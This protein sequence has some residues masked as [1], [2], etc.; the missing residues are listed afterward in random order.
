MLYSVIPGSPFRAFDANGAPLAGGKVYTW[1]PGTESD[2]TTWQDILGTTPNDN[3]VVLDATGSA[4]IYGDQEYRLRVED[5]NGGLISDELSSAYVPTSA[6][7]TAM[8]PV[9]QA[10]TTGQAINLLGIPVYVQNIV[11]GIAQT[12]GPAGPT[13]PQGIQGLTGPTGPAAGSYSPTI[14]GGNP[15]AFVIPVPNQSPLN[16]ILQS[17]IGMTNSSGILTVALPQVFPTGVIGASAT[18]V[19][20]SSGARVTAMVSFTNSTITIFTWSPDFSGNWAGAS[21]CTWM[22]IGY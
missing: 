6:I 13:G 12:T 3:P 7:S 1:I 19:G 15:G 9:L 10:S 21:Q 18:A 11:D 14:I 5:V 17:G 16:I 4:P 2:A 22:I 20:G 8:E